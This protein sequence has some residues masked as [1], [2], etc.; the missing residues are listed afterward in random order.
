MD[1][2]LEDSELPTRIAFA[3]TENASFNVGEMRYDSRKLGTLT[4]YKLYEET[5]LR[6]NS[7]ARGRLLVPTIVCRR[8]P[9][10]VC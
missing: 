4:L 10:P 3:A 6:V 1:E 2:I 8:R 5:F 7:I 9:F